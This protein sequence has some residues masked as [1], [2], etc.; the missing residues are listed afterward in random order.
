MRKF[1]RITID[2]EKKLA[3]VQ[4]GVLGVDLLHALDGTGLMTIIGGCPSVGIAG[5]TLGGGQSD[6]MSNLY[7]LASSTVQEAVII[8][9]DGRIV[10]ATREN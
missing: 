10:R 2:K 8:L 1:K 5:F 9:A 3:H 4:A 6:M 7:G